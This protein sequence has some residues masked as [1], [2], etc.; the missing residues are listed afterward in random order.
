[1]LQN[2]AGRYE[3]KDAG[4]KMVW[5]GQTVF[6]SLGTQVLFLILHLIVLQHCRRVSRG[7]HSRVA[8]RTRL[9]PEREYSGKY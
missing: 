7:T 5:N 9:F 8:E 6:T 3:K 1:M 2:S 4:I